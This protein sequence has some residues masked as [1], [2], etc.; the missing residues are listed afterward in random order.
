MIGV[1]GYAGARIGLG[2]VFDGYVRARTGLGTVFAQGDEVES[3]VN[4]GFEAIEGIFIKNEDSM[5]RPS[6]NFSNF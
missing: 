2:V 3:V 1:E 4:R 5:L 6:Q